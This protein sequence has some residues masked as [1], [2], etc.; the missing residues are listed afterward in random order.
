MTIKKACK[1]VLKRALIDTNPRVTVDE[2]GY[3]EEARDNLIE[4]VTLE[5]FEADLSQGDG[6]ELAGKF[7]AVHS[8]SALAVNTFAPFKADP[9]T[10]WLPGGGGFSSLQFEKKCPHGVAGDRAPP[11]LDVIADGPVAVVAIESKL[12]EY[13]EPREAKFSPAYER[14]IQDWRRYGPWF[15]EMTS[16]RA[17]PARYR[18]LDAAQLVKHALGLARTFAGQRATLLYLF[19]EPSNHNDFSLF[20]EHKTEIMRF[21][22]AVRGAEPTFMA[23][24][25][26][27]V[28]QAWERRTSPTNWLS[29]HVTRLRSRYEVKIKM[30]GQ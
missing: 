13:L 29:S 24:P 17:N 22:D 6:N 2:N 19:W 16:L 30:K 10:L 28:W 3:V 4:G 1:A 23:M 9:S 27:E 21:A 14:D 11:N 12:I 20:E 5:D 26:S 7:R 15:R 25:Y 18:L 8:S